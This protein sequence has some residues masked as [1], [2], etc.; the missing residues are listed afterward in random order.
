MGEE[1]TEGGR[2]QKNRWERPK[3]REKEASRGTE[4]KKKRKKENVNPSA[5]HS[6]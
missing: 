4:K 1:E 6:S 2:G 3:K 5:A